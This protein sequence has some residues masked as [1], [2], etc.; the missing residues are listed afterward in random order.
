MKLL[1]NCKSL[2]D[3]EKG[4]IVYTFIN[5]NIT[6]ARVIDYQFVLKAD[7]NALKVLSYI[8]YPTYYKFE[9]PGGE[10]FE[11]RLE[12][13]KHYVYKTVEDLRNGKCMTFKYGSY[14]I[15][16]GD[17]QNMN[18]LCAFCDLMKKKYGINRE[19]DKFSVYFNDKMS[20]RV[21]EVQF[22][23]FVIKSGVDDVEFGDGYKWHGNLGEKLANGYY[24]TRQECL[25]AYTPFVV[26]FDDVEKKPTHYNISVV[27]K[28]NGVVNDEY[29][30]FIA[31]T[32]K[33][34]K[35]VIEKDMKTR[36]VS[37]AFH[38]DASKNKDWV[39]FVVRPVYKDG[40]EGDIAY[41][42]MKY[43]N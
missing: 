11:V 30:M 5:D 31:D 1:E 32:L 33:T 24:T 14:S 42:S 34:A 35:D 22:N 16:G 7:S 4:D 28:V 43:I 6:Q 10:T 38:S 40:T 20:K 23:E 9:I 13:N 18:A 12:S 29:V 21:I 27:S 2:C 15:N 41:K 19:Y 39:Y 17:N 3:L 37:V 26:T 8:S 25:D 36:M